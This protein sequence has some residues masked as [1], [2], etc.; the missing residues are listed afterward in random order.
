VVEYPG[1]FSA[2]LRRAFCGRRFDFHDSFPV[3]DFA[4]L[5]PDVPFAFARDAKGFA[6]LQLRTSA[7]AVKWLKSHPPDTMLGLGQPPPP[8]AL[9]A[10]REQYDQPLEI[11]QASWST[12][13]PQFPLAMDPAHPEQA[14]P[15]KYVEQRRDA[16]WF[17]GLVFAAIF[18]AIGLAVWLFGMVFLFRGLAPPLFWLATLT[19][20]LALPWASDGLPKL[21]RYFNHN[22]GDIAT[23]VV[24]DLSRGTRIE[25]FEPGDAWQTDG[26]RIEIYADRGRYSDSFGK[27]P[28]R[29]PPQ[30]LTAQQAMD[31]L[32][33]QTAVYVAGLD[34]ASTASLFLR[35]RELYDA[36]LRHTQLL[37]DEAALAVLKNADL[38][39]RAHTAAKKFLMF[40]PAGKFY[41]DQLEATE[42]APKTT[43]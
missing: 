7:D 17:G 25:A 9:D 26:E 30:T 22:W 15:A 20:L 18:F 10:L 12:P 31:A 40:A 5:A 35:L 33:E 37:F 28:F 39:A 19:P 16:F 34:S 4:T 1:D 8:T 13:T 41:Q 11:A 42:V 27:I 36:N 29:K 2:P 21:V 38:D 32:S 3:T 14:M 43:P 6:V 24:N 23:D